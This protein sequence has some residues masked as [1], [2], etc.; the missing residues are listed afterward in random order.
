MSTE[1]PKPTIS[2]LPTSLLGN[3]MSD[4]DSKEKA[5]LYQLNRPIRR[6]ASKITTP[7]KNT[8]DF[9]L[10][11]LDLNWTHA[12]SRPDDTQMELLHLITGL[13]NEQIIAREFTPFS[14][15][16]LDLVYRILCEN[17][18][19]RE[20]YPDLRWCKHRLFDR[21]THTKDQPSAHW[22]SLGRKARRR[23]YLAALIM[24]CPFFKGGYKDTEVTKMEFSSG[25]KAIL[26]SIV[27]TIIALI[28]TCWAPIVFGVISASTIPYISSGVSILV[29]IGVGKLYGRTS[30]NMPWTIAAGLFFPLTLL[31][32]IAQVVYLTYKGRHLSD[33]EDSRR[34]DLLFIQPF[35]TTNFKRRWLSTIA[36]AAHSYRPDP[37]ELYVPP[38]PIPVHQEVRSAP[39]TI[40]HPA[41][42]EKQVLMEAKRSDLNVYRSFDI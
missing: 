40:P 20:G 9:F 26:L 31:L 36:V 21:L 1:T 38:L 30:Q 5:K 13:T 29:A 15:K 37:R 6:E 33:E 22:V 12:Q 42:P 17:W 16:Q 23:P 34:L 27:S 4:L 35:N 24:D 25:M 10:D 7:T 14:M 28:L 11:R 18:K 41:F 19:P 39:A 8:H 3:I 2:T 32:N